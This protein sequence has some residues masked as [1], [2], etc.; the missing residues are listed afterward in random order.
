MQK[1][2]RKYSSVSKPAGSEGTR[3]L[4]AKPKCKSR[5]SAVTRLADN[6]GRRILLVEPAASSSSVQQPAAT[7]A[8]DSNT[9]MRSDILDRLYEACVWDAGTKKWRPENIGPLFNSTRSIGR[10]SWEAITQRDVLS[11]CPVHDSSKT[12]PTITGRTN[13]DWTSCSLLMILGGFATTQ[14]RNSFGLTRNCQQTL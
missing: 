2:K 14:E 6:E 5:A 3:L 1:C 7:I 13:R 11:R 10:K 4:P 12:S 8:L 9:D